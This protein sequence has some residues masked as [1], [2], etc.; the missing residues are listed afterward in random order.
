MRVWGLSI[1]PDIKTHIP[2]TSR[3][4][5]HDILLSFSKF[6]CVLMKPEDLLPSSQQPSTGLFSKLDKFSQ[7]VLN[8]YTKDTF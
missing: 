7:R 6:Y 2:G 4:V 3:V 8:I 1:T 5:V